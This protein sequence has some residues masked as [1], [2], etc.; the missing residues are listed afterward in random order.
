MSVKRHHIKVCFRTAAL[1]FCIFVMSHFDVVAKDFVVVLDA[2]HG[3]HD[4]G[5]LGKSCRE[6]DI[7]LAVT[8]LLGNKIKNEFDDVKVVY[9]RSRDVFVPLNKRAKTANNASGDLFISIHCNSVAEGRERVKG[10]SVFT[11]GT[12]RAS[13][14]F[15]VAKRENSVI[16]LEPDFTTSYQGFDPNSS[17]SYIIFE[18]SQNLHMRQSVS[19]A[20]MV[21]RELV[22]RANRNDMGVR[23]DNFWV[24]WATAMPA[25][26]IEL[27]FICNPTIES[28]LNSTKGQ[29]QMASAIFSAFKKY[30]STFKR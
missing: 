5:A 26:L 15:D 3:G 16:T 14:N 8:R 18:M 19:F 2:G 9:T 13:S 20:Q 4:T 24:L 27:D 17:E 7:N 23:Q 12:G 21:Q 6:K 25:V 28:Y 29:E 22:K 1:L 11:L 30:K 10:A